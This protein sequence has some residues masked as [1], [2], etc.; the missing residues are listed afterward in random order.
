MEPVATFLSKARD[1]LKTR[2]HINSCFL[3][4]FLL[5][6]L[7]QQEYFLRRIGYHYIGIEVLLHSFLFRIQPIQFFCFLLIW[8]RPAQNLDFLSIC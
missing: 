3:M 8:Y 6:A 4:M 2:T 7:N 5:S 1:I